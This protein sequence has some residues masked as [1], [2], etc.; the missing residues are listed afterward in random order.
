M[1][2]AS[3]FLF[4]HCGM[5]FSI[6]IYDTFCCHR[7][8][9]VFFERFVFWWRDGSID[10]YFWQL[11]SGAIPSTCW[12][13]E[14]TKNRNNSLE[15]PI[16]KIPTI[17]WSGNVSETRYT[18]A[19]WLEHSNVEKIWIFLG[20]EGLPWTEIIGCSEWSFAT[21]ACTKRQTPWEE[22]LNSYQPCPF[23]KLR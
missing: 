16:F 10:I 23:Q 17:R 6:Q 4:Q 12:A 20:P 8:A 18:H 1:K 11:F 9:L 22:V 2:L 19:K 5:K 7:H 21:L 15:T 3:I 14:A 13:E